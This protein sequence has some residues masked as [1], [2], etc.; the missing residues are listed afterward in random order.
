LMNQFI[1]PVIF[2]RA[3]AVV[4]EAQSFQS[5]EVLYQAIAAFSTILFMVIGTAYLFS[6][7][8]V[9]IVTAPEFVAYHQLLWI[10]VMGVGTFHVAQMFTLKGA[11]HNKT[12][13]YV[14]PKLLQA[15]TQISLLLW[16][17]ST[18]GIIGA[19]WSLFGSSFVYLCAVLWVNRNIGP[20]SDWCET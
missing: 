9:E 7:L 4:N 15:G 3:G 14:I 6:D 16:L 17:T 8:L 19:A 10:V 11:S 5:T 13:S 20:I 12:R 18:M 1:V 2:D